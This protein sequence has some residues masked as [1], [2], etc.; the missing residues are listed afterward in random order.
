MLCASFATSVALLLALAASETRNA[1]C[2]IPVIL[3]SCV[4]VAWPI[5]SWFAFLLARVTKVPQKAPFTASA[6]VMTNSVFAIC[7]ARLADSRAII[8]QAWESTSA[9]TRWLAILAVT[10]THSA[11]GA[12]VLTRVSPPSFFAAV[13]ACARV[14]VACAS[15]AA[16][17]ARNFA[18]V[19]MPLAALALL[20]KSSVLCTTCFT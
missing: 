3:V 19:T 1:S 20:A 16:V 15:N 10:A 2:A 4:R 17:T 12:C 5:A 11:S 9:A 7:W 6:I 13:I 14:F 8:R 18:L